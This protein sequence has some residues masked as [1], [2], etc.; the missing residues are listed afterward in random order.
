MKK[1]SYC[2]SRNPAET[3][4]FC[5][6]WGKLQSQKTYDLCLKDRKKLSKIKV[7]TKTKSFIFLPS[8]SSPLLNERRLKKQLSEI[9]IKKAL[10]EIS[11]LDIKRKQNCLNIYSV[12]SYQGKLAC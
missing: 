2:V 6:D 1:C 9:T 8:R 12:L 10:M 7:E 3:F 11:I 5:Y 4:Y